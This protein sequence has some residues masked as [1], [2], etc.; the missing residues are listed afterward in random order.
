MYKLPQR[1]AGGAGSPK[2]ERKGD[3]M[4]T[5]YFDEIH[6]ILREVEQTQAQSMDLLSE[7]MA[8]AIR[9][10]KNI[11]AFGCS[12]A[13]ILAEELFYR[14]GGLAVINP[15]LAPGL[16]LTVR[17][18]TM[19]TQIERLEGYGR[20]IVKSAG[21][22][23][24]DV[25]IIHS[26]SGRN[27]VPVE[28][29]LEAG[30]R[31]AFVAGLTN[32]AYSKSVSSRA[33]CGKRLFEICDCVIDNCGSVGDSVCEIEG[34]PEKVAASSTAVGAAILNAVVA[35]TVEL[36]VQSGVVPPVFLSANVEGGDAHND[37][38]LKKYEKN[39]KY[40]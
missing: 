12:H 34:M 26:V 3:S 28:A 20:T 19:T 23:E 25:L 32:L 5:Q 17:P 22:A 35:Q 2:T 40:M 36:L 7:R 21:I 10:R 24:G 8:E 38:M 14:T 39:I 33:S 11:Y 13:G 29:A 16:T 6:R 31:G 1:R 4:K 15:I 9:T 27:P 30:A 18:V 37:E